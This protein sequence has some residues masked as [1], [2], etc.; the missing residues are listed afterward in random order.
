MSDWIDTLTQQ[1]NS[2]EA[3]KLHITQVLP[4]KADDFWR[5]LT[6]AI[7]QDIQRINEQFKNRIGKI[8]FQVKDFLTLHITKLD[9]PAYYIDIILNPSRTS[10]RVEGQF[11]PNSTNRNDFKSC[12]LELK[13][14]KNDNLIVK[15]ESTDRLTPAAISEAV[16]KPV[17]LSEEPVDFFSHILK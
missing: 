4:D 16:L 17:I 13:L 2:E 6:E 7:R 12:P 10:I 14:D 8:D 1:I 15:G 11:V 3:R 9:F 5:H